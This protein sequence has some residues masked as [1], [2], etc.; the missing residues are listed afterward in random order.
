MPTRTY[1]IQG[2]LIHAHTKQPL[3]DLRIEAWDKDLLFDDLVGSTVTDEAGAFSFTFEEPYFQELFLDRRPDLFFKIYDGH[4]LV[5]DTRDS[6]LWNVRRRKSLLIEVDLSQD[7]SPAN[8]IVQG[9]VRY[10]DGRPIESSRDPKVKA[11]DKGCCEDKQ[12]GETTTPDANGFYTIAYKR[13]DLLFQEKGTANLFVSCTA[14]GVEIPDS[15][16][17]FKAAKNVT[18]DLT[19]GGEAY[20]GPSEFTQAWTAVSKVCGKKPLADFTEELID[21]VANDTGQAREKV[22]DLVNSAKL[23]RESEYDRIEVFY[24]LLRQHLPASLATLLSQGPAVWRADLENAVTVNLVSARELGDIEAI[25]AAL[26]ALAELRGFWPPK[27]DFGR[28]EVIDLH[29]L[30]GQTPKEVEKQNPDLFKLLQKKALDQLRQ[31]VTEH[32]AESPDRLRKHWQ[33]LDLTPLLQPA[34]PIKD[35]LRASL[36]QAKLDQSLI[37]ESLI[38]IN[39]LQASETLDVI[40]QP[41]IPLQNNPIIQT[42]LR[43]GVTYRLGEFTQ[44]SSATIQQLLKRAV[45]PEFLQPEILDRLV[46]EGVLKAAEARDLTLNA[47]LYRLSSGNL[48]LVQAIKGNAPLNSLED[49]AG[50]NRADWEHLL[51]VSEIEP[52]AKVTR[53]QYAAFLRKQVERLYPHQTFKSQHRPVEAGSFTQNLNRVAPLFDLN[54]RLFG[55][56]PFSALKL[57]DINPDDKPA[58]EAAY[59]SLTRSANRNPGLQL[60]KVLNNRELSSQEKLTEF[61][62]RVNLMP[63]FHQL[64]PGVTFLSLD[65]SPDSDDVAKLKFGSFSEQDKKLVLDNLKADQRIYRVTQ[66]SEDAHLVMES[67]YHTA[68][69]IVSDSRSS[70]A[71]N[72]GVETATAYI[73]YDR[74]QSATTETT[75]RVGTVLDYVTGGL[76]PTP[77]DNTSSEIRP[78]LQRHYGYSDFFGNQNYCKCKHC[79]SII[80]PVAY[81]VDLMDFLQTNVLD[82]HFPGEGANTNVLNPRVRRS[83]L[84]ESLALTCEN[85]N[86]LVP[87]LTIINEI[88]ENYI[89]NHPDSDFTGELTDRSAVEDFVYTELYNLSPLNSF[90]Q[91]FHLPL[92]ELQTYLSHFSITRAEVAQ[93]VR[94]FVEDSQE[95]IP[96]SK[97]GLSD[98]EYELISTSN[99]DATFLRNLY[100]I[101]FS[102]SDPIDPV[103]AQEFIR[104]MEIT[105]QDLTKLIGTRFITANN[106]DDPEGVRGV[107]IEPELIPGELQFNVEKVKGLTL[108]VLDRMHR[109]TR[110]WRAIALTI[111]ELDQLLFHISNGYE[112]GF[113]N[114]LPLQELTDLITLQKQLKVSVPELCALFDRISFEYSPSLFDRLFNIPAFARVVSWVPGTLSLSFQHPAYRSDLPD[115]AGAETL[116]R[117][118]AGLAIND[119]E[120]F[121]LI[122]NLS[123]ALGANSTGSFTL[124]LQNLSIL[125]RHAR[126]AKAFK[127]TISELF[128]LIRMEAS[129]SND[130]VEN[131]AGLMAIVEL[132]EW[133]KTSGYSLNELAFI[134][135]ETLLDEDS[136]TPAAEISDGIREQADTAK[137]LIFA[138]TVFAYFEGITE[139]Q[140]QAIIR[141]NSAVITSADNGIF[142]IT[143]SVLDHLVITYPAEITTE[144]QAILEPFIRGLIATHLQ[145]V[146]PD[147]PDQVLAGVARLSLDQSRAILAA[148]PSIFTST[149]SGAYRITST[150]L[151][152]IAITY[153]A[154][155]TPAQQAVLE[156]VIR[157]LIIT[158]LQPGAPDIDNQVFV[159]IADLSLDQSRAILADNSSIFAIVEDKT[160][161]WLSP[162]FDPATPI[163]I[164]AGIP[165][166]AD[167]AHAY[168]LQYHASEI[169]PNLLGNLLNLPVEKTKALALL[170]GYDFASPALG[171]SLTRILQS[172]ASSDP[173]TTLVAAVQKLAVLFKDKDFDAEALDFVRT[174]SG[175]LRRIFHISNYLSPSLED[176]QEITR[177]RKLLEASQ[178][179]RESFHKILTRFDFSNPDPDPRLRRFRDSAID[180]LTIVLQ[181]ERGLIVA[182]NQVIPFPTTDPA[183][184]RVLEALEKLKDCVALAQSL[185]VAG[186]ALPLIISNDFAEITRAV[187]TIVTAIRT[188]YATE[189]EWQSKFGLFEDKIREM[190]RDALTDYLIHTLMPDV[191]QHP[192]DLYHY[193]LI[194]T[195]LEGCAR[196]SRVVAGISSLQLY[197]QRCVMNLEQS[198]DG[199]VHVLPEEIPADQWEW[200]KNYRVWEANRKVFLYPETYIEPDLRDDKTPLFE[201]LESELLQQ[202]INAQTALDAYAKYMKGFEE[203]SRLKIAGAYHDRENGADVLHLFGVT[204]S[205]PPV[206]YYRTVENIYLAEEPE[207]SKGIVWNPWRKINVQI[208]ARKVSP[209]VFLGKLHVFWVEISTR[210]QN[211]VINGSSRFAGY[212]H[213][214]SV[215][216]TTLRLDGAWTAPQ[217]ILLQ[218]QPFTEGDGV[219]LDP[220]FEPDETSPFIVHP[221]QLKSQIIQA[222][223]AKLLQLVKGDKLLLEETSYP[224]TV[225]IEGPEGEG[226][227]NQ[228]INFTDSRVQSLLIP[229][230]DTNIHVETIDGYTLTGFRWDQV[231]PDKKGTEVLAIV[232]ADFEMRSTLDFYELKINPRFPSNNSSIFISP[233][234]KR[235]NV[236]NNLISYL[237]RSSFSSGEAYADAVKFL[238]N[239]GGGGIELGLIAD[240]PATSTSLFTVSVVNGTLTDGIIDVNGD[241]L[242]IHSYERRG[243]PYKLKRIGTTLSEQVSRKLFEGGLDILLS[244]QTQG[245]LEEADKPINIRENWIE[246]DTNEGKLDLTGSLGVYFREIF[247]HIPFLIANHLNSQGKYAD[248]QRWYHYIFDPGSNNMPDLSGITDTEELERRSKDR[249]WQYKEFRNRTLE[250]LRE[251]LNNPEAIATYERNP[252]NPHAI[253]RLRKS[254]AYM[255]SIVMK[256]IDNLLDWADH[257]FAQDTMESINEATLLYVMAAEILGPRPAELGDCPENEGGALTY[258]AIRELMNARIAEGFPAEMESTGA[259]GRPLAGSNWMDHFGADVE[260][261]SI[262]G[263]DTTVSGSEY[264]RGPDWRMYNQW[265][266]HSPVPSF[267]TSLLRQATVFCI[268]HNADL[269]G[270]WDRVQDR[271][272]KIRNCLNISG[273]RRQLPLFAPEIDPRLLVR[274]RAAGLSLDEALNSISGNLPPYRFSFLMAKAK[275]YAG[276]LQAFGA[277]LLGALEKKDA[278]ELAKLRLV[279]QDNILKLTTKLRD[280]EIEAA[281][282]SLEAL[283]RRLDTVTGRRDHY[284]DLLNNGPS[285]W[286][287]MQRVTKHVGNLLMPSI[288]LYHLL[289]GKLA[290]LPQILGFSNSTGAHGAEK[291]MEAAGFAL[292]TT[293]DYSNRIADSAEL[294]ASFHRR[295]EGW[296][297]NLEQA[298]KDL[299][300]LEKQI[301]GAEIRL[302]ISIESRNLHEK[303]IEQ[304][305]ETFEF[306]Q[307]KFTNLGLYTFLSAN[308][309]RLY[310]ASYQNALTMARLTERAFRFERGDDT[311]PFWDGNYWDATHAGLLAG[312]R[313]MN[314][315]REMERRY[316]ETHYRSMEIDQAF[317]LTQIAPAALLKLKA[318]GECEFSIPE[319]YFDLFYPGQYRRRIKSARLTIPCI[320]GPYT[321]VSATLSLTGSQIRKD[322]KLGDENLFDVPPTRSV[323]I[324]AS[325]G[326]NDSGV[327]RL[328][329]RDERYMPFEGAGAVNSEWN[330]SLPKTFR[331]FDYATIND[332]IIHISYT[333]EY[334]G[335]FR[336]LMETQIATVQGALETY[337]SEISTPRVFSFRQEFSQTF[338]RLLHS[339]EGTTVPLELS[340]KHF[341]L[342]L[343]GRKLEISAAKLIVEIDE[344]GFRNEDGDVALPP[345]FT[346]VLIVAGNKVVSSDPPDPP[347]T[348]ST[349]IA[350]FSMDPALGMPSADIDLSIFSP[351]LPATAPLR[352]SLTVNDA[353]VFAPSAPSPSDPSAL[354]EHK[355]KDV[356]LYLEYRIRTS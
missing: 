307:D 130:C 124:N 184:N 114:I 98:K 71:R 232:G 147:I 281:E 236:E 96:Q 133:R 86:T 74:A 242:Y 116:H 15:P 20:R 41:E 323:T 221:E 52:P 60:S 186:E 244:I 335:V 77:V 265:S 347:E 345:S 161:Y 88:L 48:T 31:T 53:K 75:A 3:P 42:E 95:L 120:L 156:P 151:S 304:L 173:L 12:V 355:V 108:G 51:L 199:S 141:A 223:A 233:Q 80:G 35:F 328:D 135:G 234:D 291:D 288:V 351:F 339:R 144:Q 37:R 213:T 26:L 193:F 267:G 248:A 180:D 319:L 252:F 263:T 129:L 341:P 326:Q 315:L 11:Y 352:L 145:P 27:P 275:E 261:V 18:I 284:H 14:D 168:L 150:V 294:E 137:S 278:E 131:L 70:F 59:Q 219:I 78:Y 105:R 262:P 282:A 287:N 170:A 104:S 338:H 343:Q 195:E 99:A 239:I 140:S 132:A 171:A 117:L 228:N 90:R 101:N 100:R 47:N 201:E 205:E 67:G 354:D 153:P 200:R 225:T 178:A 179:E 253:A 237:Y 148:N 209:I 56:I 23:A 79:A 336:G 167:A 308:L 271:L 258:V 188:K 210:P 13:N 305:Q 222:L 125:Y 272:Y 139:A 226:R 297:F 243:R 29:A 348:E 316:M 264:F 92:V 36:H 158:H 165:L 65:Y 119:D 356:Y 72:T 251:Q 340:E 268:P 227:Y 353:D 325:T 152:S 157:D 106:P 344:N 40:L 329:F 164:P 94:A 324:A 190:K 224:V 155:I 333:A 87:Y 19:V 334:D 235:L 331:P 30:A 25:L 318:T 350:P 163:T 277:A 320:T 311:T 175:G 349:T 214:M 126:L 216:F 322:P 337:L 84:W 247:F 82:E 230:Y 240:I 303:S 332:V 50:M 187:E 300:E 314:D 249:V 172:Q 83:D 38:K 1:T 34:Q 110:L 207:S 212:K 4:R 211:D 204:S 8:F 217:K 134:L 115:T 196:T 182:L 17:V 298:N 241:L 66:D 309:Q 43:Q 68:L 136:F 91:P 10:S 189:E 177:Y 149:G 107:R 44:L 260:V 169:V 292:R 321:N 111:E 55:R 198:E 160:L 62:R 33:F 301:E 45:Y 159:G 21:Y 7:D 202:D 112:D 103:D 259:G 121:L 280:Q 138:D 109:F 142:R 102:D 285:E 290:Y 203:I 313:L 229:R 245:D 85:T 192:N 143:S 269:L 274:A 197:I 238:N 327:F 312:E 46:N 122:E 49:L 276:A 257:L 123:S 128:L 302:A 286:E 127:L 279:Q 73:Y 194:D 346:I 97:L 2:T 266:N 317:S 58:L 231:Y 69:L 28:D 296:E 183:T 9:H 54:A 76:E 299:A 254:G 191:F 342:F 154:D 256:Y 206:Y 24:A 146:A 215:K 118:L 283:N 162:A 93:K 57:G 5:H 306:Y 246:N 330:L 16:I 218:G 270:Y 181:A 113:Q 61:S 273:I 32:F 310:R 289:S 22:A 6:V 293:A 63:T 208:A 174:H 64:N 295:E 255:K 81:F 185:G 166:R 250:T 89:A 176:I 220:L 39:D